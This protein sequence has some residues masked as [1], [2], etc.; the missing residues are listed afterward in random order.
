MDFP[1]VDPAR[2]IGPNRFGIK[3]GDRRM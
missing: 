2:E 3:H 1:D